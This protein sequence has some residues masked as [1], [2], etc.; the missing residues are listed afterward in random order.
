VGFTQVYQ[1][2]NA[3]DESY[4]ENAPRA[5]DVAGEEHPAPE[6]LDVPPLHRGW[7]LTWLKCWDKFSIHS[8]LTTYKGL[9][10]LN[11]NL[12]LV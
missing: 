1:A 7:A 12:A 2:E 8:L 4:H 3:K 9:I 11:Y 5:A 6:S 10:Q